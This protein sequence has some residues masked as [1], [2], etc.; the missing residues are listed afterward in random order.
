VV[1]L[2]HLPHLPRLVEPVTQR[3]RLRSWL[4][5]DRE[6]FAA[7]N[8]DPEVMRYFPEM[9]TRK[10]SDAFVDRIEARMAELGYGLWALELLSTGG[11]LGFTGLNPMPDGGPGAGGLEVGWRLARSAWGHG[12]ATEAGRA[13]LAVAFGDA[14]LDEVWS[15]TTVVNA[16]SRAVMERLGLRHMSTQD[17]PDLDPG[18]PISEHVYY[19]V[20]RSDFIGV[21]P[22]ETT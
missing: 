12:Y 2:D 20:T 6:A 9:L 11:F 4:P 8:A 17:H 16:P 1:S 7:M 19:R 3:L 18:S 13:A 10:Q 5:A 15:L 21:E 22:V 14:G